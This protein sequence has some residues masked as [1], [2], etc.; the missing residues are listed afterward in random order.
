[1]KTTSDFI[2]ALVRCIDEL[3]P[4]YDQHIKD[5]DLLLP[6]VFLGDVTRYVVET[7]L[8]NSDDKSIQDLLSLFEEALCDGPEEVK[9]LVVVSFLEDLIGEEHALKV[10]KRKMPIHLRKQLNLVLDR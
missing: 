4:I 2:L 6:H 7:A 9:E 8:R 5:N 10:L 1:M 3:K